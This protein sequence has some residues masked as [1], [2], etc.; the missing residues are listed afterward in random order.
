MFIWDHYRPLWSVD[1]F[2][3]MNSFKIAITYVEQTE[4]ENGKV[5]R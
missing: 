2:H 5:Q 3:D 4:P 1:D